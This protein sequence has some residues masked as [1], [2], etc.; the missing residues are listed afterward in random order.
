MEFSDIVINIHR[1]VSSIFIVMAIVLLVRSIAGW[2]LRK[3]YTVFDRNISAVLLALLY[4][5]LVVGLLL[6]FELGNQQGGATSMEE[7]TRAMSIRFWA[8]EHFIVM[9]FALLLTQV[10]WIFINKSKL[11]LNKHKNTLFY[12]GISILLIII[13]T[14]VGIIMR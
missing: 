3:P 9:M 14:G 10:G 6:Y 7:A 5:Q 11:D 1:V 8:L 2:R 13:S 4:A 12:F